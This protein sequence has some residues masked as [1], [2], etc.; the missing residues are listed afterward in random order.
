MQLAEAKQHFEQLGDDTPPEVRLTAGT[1]LGRWYSLGGHY[2]ELTELYPAIAAAFERSRP[3]PDLTRTFYHHL[4]ETVL[5]AAEIGNFTTG[6]EAARLIENLAESEEFSLA[7]F[8]AVLSVAVL[9]DRLGD[10]WQAQRHI[11]SSFTRYLA[12]FGPP[13]PAR[14]LNHKVALLIGMY[15]AERD[16]GDPTKLESILNEARLCAEQAIGCISDDDPVDTKG[17][18]SA[19]LAAIYTLCGEFD[20][21]RGFVEQARTIA[22]QLGAHGLRRWAEVVHAAL[23]NETGHPNEALDSVSALLTDDAIDPGS[24]T[25]RRA[26]RVGYEAAKTLGDTATALRFLQDIHTTHRTR[27]SAQLKAQSELFTHRASVR[28][29]AE[30][31]RRKAE[32][33]PLTGLG[34][35]RLFERRINTLLLEAERLHRPLSLALFDLDNFKRV[36]DQ[37]GHQTGDEV[38][39]AFG[40]LLSRSVR[41]D[42]IAVRLG[43]EEFV[44]IFP[45]TDLAHATE[46]A[47]HIRVDCE[48]AHWPEV[49]NPVTVSAGVASTPPYSG[50]QLLAEADQWLY[51]AKRGGR[52]LVANSSTATGGNTRSAPTH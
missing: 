49:G 37:L 12:R 20:R 2:R 1:E 50:T 46:I 10:T 18:L 47:E 32:T 22:R 15:H 30:S 4:R 25:G 11:E 35:R 24:N 36:N 13:I 52:N 5:A 43:G 19:N 3:D 16:F 44:V 29:L 23:L 45:H 51:E 21:A 8:K 38:L 17:V 7:R 31:Q 34:N 48:R 27:S 28:Q 26:H 42:D 6:F 40:Q 33:D 39:T 41:P 14:V 9:L